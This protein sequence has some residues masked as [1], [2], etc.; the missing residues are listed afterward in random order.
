MSIEAVL[1]KYW[2]MGFVIQ[3]VPGKAPPRAVVPGVPGRGGNAARDDLGA[4][5][6]IRTF[7]NTA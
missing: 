4:K 3:I 6:A 1:R 7:L 5:T 2:S